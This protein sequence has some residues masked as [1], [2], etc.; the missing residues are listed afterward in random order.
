VAIKQKKREI[1]DTEK[2]ETTGT[3]DGGTGKQ[4]W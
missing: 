1:K 2:A 4:L 3:T